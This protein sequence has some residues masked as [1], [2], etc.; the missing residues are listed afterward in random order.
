MRSILITLVLLVTLS[1]CNKDVEYVNGTEV[2]DFPL[3][4]VLPNFNFPNITVEPIDGPI[5]LGIDFSF[6]NI[7]TGLYYNGVGTQDKVWNFF[8]QN[9][10][11]YIVTDKNTGIVVFGIAGTYELTE[12]DFC[13]QGADLYS[14]DYSITHGT[15]VG[16]EYV[17]N[18]VL[19]VY[20]EG[21]G[22]VQYAENCE[23][24]MVFERQ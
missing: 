22:I 11:E 14:L 1:S 9:Q 18:L 20:D 10:V 6:S 3:T 24:Y 17:T 16:E 8:G 19:K 7:P 5:D 23:P 21:A 15:G 4:Q 13:E 2:Q 12:A